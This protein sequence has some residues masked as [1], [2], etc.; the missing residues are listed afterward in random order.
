MNDFI[1]EVNGNEE[2]G[3]VNVSALTHDG[4]DDGEGGVPVREVS[5]SIQS[6]F[7]D[8]LGNEMEGQS[9]PQSTQ[10]LNEPLL[11]RGR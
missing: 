2:V 7:P 1:F 8:L 4:D 10:S 11:S 5:V 3:R 6:I 9:Q